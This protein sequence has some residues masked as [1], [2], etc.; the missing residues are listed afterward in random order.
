LLGLPQRTQRHFS[1]NNYYAGS[2]SLARTGLHWRALLM[3]P[4]QGAR[5]G[6]TRLGPRGLRVAADLTDCVT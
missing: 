4:S 3:P 6:V 1:N 2:Q 5:Y